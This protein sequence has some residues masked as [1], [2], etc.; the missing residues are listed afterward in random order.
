MSAGARTSVTIKDIAREAGISAAAV[1]YALRNSPKIAKAT[2]KQVKA[3]ALRLGYRPD[4]RI[5]S[6]MAHIRRA[7]A[8]TTGERLA[9]VWVHTSRTQAARDPFLLHVFAGA[10][11]RAE[12]SG[13]RL[14]EFWTG[15]AGMTDERLQAIIRTRGIVGVVLSPVLSNEATLALNWDW[16]A[17]A[18]AVIGNVTWTPELHHAG[19]HHYLGMRMAVLELGKLGRT[20][21]AALL[22]A[23]TNE[24][25]KRA[26]EA[27]FLTHH[28]AREEAAAMA[29]VLAPGDFGAAT[30]WLRDLDTD[31]L[32]VS[33]TRL[34]DSAALR[35]VCRE[36]RLPIVT[37]HRSNESAGVGGI[38]Q[39]YD[40]IAGHAIDLV[41]AQLNSNETG[42]PD[43]PRIMLF[44]GRWVPPR[45]PRQRG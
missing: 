31:A 12:Q 14:E 20:R 19:H 22:E 24:R 25:A 17:F 7:H 28:P 16:S 40:R 30:A 35:A 36:R 38:D 23:E 32:I 10:R 27:A 3:I 15:D 45:L 44:P 18:V 1:S 6:L 8:R 9:F 43:L 33:T 42:V 37:L 21:P 39:C 26:W 29:R 4:P 13:F 2:Q 11:R 41:V 5:A 34:L